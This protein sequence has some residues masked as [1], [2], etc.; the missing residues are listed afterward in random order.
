MTDL[1][2]HRL[3]LLLAI[4]GA[5]TIVAQTWNNLSSMR[6]SG[7]LPAF[8]RSLPDIREWPIHTYLPV[9]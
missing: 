2:R 1:T 4:L 8:H 3:S 5:L 6:S 7:T 9:G